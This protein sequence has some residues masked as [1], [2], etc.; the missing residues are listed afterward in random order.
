MDH[1]E[2]VK[3]PEALKPVLGAMT[4]RYLGWYKDD[5]TNEVEIRGE[6]RWGG[7]SF[8]CSIQLPSELVLID[9]KLEAA[10]HALVAESIENEGELEYRIG[11]IHKVVPCVERAAK[12]LCK[13][14]LKPANCPEGL[15]PVPRVRRRAKR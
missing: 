10:C 7:L 9:E 15:R 1:E 5:E 3:L 4:V 6:V 12:R 8:D 14:L 2:N 13:F 11:Y